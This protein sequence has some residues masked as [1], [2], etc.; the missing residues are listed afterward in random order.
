[1]RTRYAVA[2]W[3]VGTI[4]L[5]LAVR[6]LRMLFLT[7]GPRA[8]CPNCGS[9]ALRRARPASAVYGSTNELVLDRLFS[10]IGC[11]AHRCGGCHL[12]F[13]RPAIRLGDQAPRGPERYRLRQ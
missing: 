5:I 6:I 4:V 10:L 8:M 12:R 7:M 13:H 9:S 11:L 1:M 2:L 3:M